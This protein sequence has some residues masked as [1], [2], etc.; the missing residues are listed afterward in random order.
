MKDSFDRDHL[1]AL[2]RQLGEL[3]QARGETAAIVVV[4]GAALSLKGLVSRATVDIDVIAIGGGSSKAP[5]S[6]L[7]VP[8]D[9]PANLRSAV[10]RLT[11]DLGLPP[12]WMNTFVTCGGTQRLP[13]GFA[14]RVEWQEHQGLWLGIAGRYD[15]IALKLHAAIDTDIR[16]RHTSDL[17]ALRPTTEELESAGAWVR[18]QDAGPDFQGLVSQVISHVT[19]NAR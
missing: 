1:L 8:M 9:L 16:S 6:V 17:L 5:P 15:L 13:P 14:D 7:I 3:L 12:S 10:D 18:S 19:A 2:I 11:R 4:G